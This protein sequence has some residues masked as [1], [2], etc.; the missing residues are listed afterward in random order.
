MIVI[1][2]CGGSGSGKGTVSKI[3]LEYGI[4]SIDTDAVYH[5]ITSYNSP[6][7]RALSIEFGEDIIA[8][9]NRLDRKKLGSI[10]FTSKDRLKRLNEITH[11]YIL[12]EVR[13]SLLEYEKE[14]RMAAIVDAPLLFESGFN[15]ECD[16]TVCVISDEEK[17]ISRIVDRDGITYETA[18][19]RIGTQI[20][21]TEL[22]NL[23]DY[24]ITNNDDIPSLRSQTLRIAKLILENKHE[25]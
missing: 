3:F 18:K 19:K 24:V 12:N 1:G 11:R 4:P 2:L 21:D 25:R 16:L 9:G 7:L 10:V 15:E 17:R 13:N 20:N 5:N 22:V 23:C 8:D 14:G 6:C